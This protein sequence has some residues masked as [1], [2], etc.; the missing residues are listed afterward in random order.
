MIGLISRRRDPAIVSDEAPL[1]G[2]N[3][4][5]TIT[6]T[7]TPTGG[8]YKLSFGGDETTAI[9]HNADTA[10]VL[11]ALLAL[12]SINISD[13]HQYESDPLTFEFVGALGLQPLAEITLSDNSLE[14]GTDPSVTIETTTP[15]VVPDMA[16]TGQAW[17]EVGVTMYFNMGTYSAPAW[18]SFPD[19]AVVLG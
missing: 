12:D 13:I 11:A 1:N 17:V 19:M 14:G 7:G 5:Q 2:T 18:T 6:V 16:K 15:G 10:A 3:A 4:V 9:A 8:T